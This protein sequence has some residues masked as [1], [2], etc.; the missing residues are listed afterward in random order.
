MTKFGK[1]KFCGKRPLDFL[2]PPNTHCVFVPG[3][4]S[5]VSTLGVMG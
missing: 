4:F 3:G 5:F 2:S 1:T